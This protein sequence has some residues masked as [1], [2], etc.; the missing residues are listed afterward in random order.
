M[1][2]CDRECAIN[3]LGHVCRTWAQGV[4]LEGSRRHDARC[5][6]CGG[7]AVSRSQ[8][9]P[10]GDVRRAHP[11]AG[12]S[13]RYRLWEGAWGGGAGAGLHEPTRDVWAQRARPLR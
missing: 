3:G 9:A 1:H 11:H 8:A 5:G 12:A 6:Q 7:A 4:L 13:E 2:A 10:A